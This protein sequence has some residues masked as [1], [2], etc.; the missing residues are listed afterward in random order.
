MLRSRQST[1]VQHSFH[2]FSWRELGMPACQID[3]PHLLYNFMA[4]FQIVHKTL[5]TAPSITSEFLK[6]FKR[7]FYL[8]WATT[9]IVDTGKMFH[10]K[11]TC[12]IFLS[13]IL[14]WV[15]TEYSFSRGGV[16]EINHLLFSALTIYINCM[17]LQELLTA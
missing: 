10:V 4:H 1:D 5:L 8:H 9:A 17:H 16:V 15:R 7:K 12:K 3:L 6:M 13:L 2:F 11:S 14:L